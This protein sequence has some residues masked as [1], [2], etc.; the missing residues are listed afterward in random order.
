MVRLA[1][2]LIQIVQISAEYFL[3][4]YGSRKVD[5]NYLERMLFVDFSV[6]S[7]LSSEFSKKF[8]KIG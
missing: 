4:A 2:G 8:M 7:E 5:D 1:N 6:N 3:P